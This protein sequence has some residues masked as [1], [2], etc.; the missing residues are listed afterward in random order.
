MTGA[1]V[2]RSMAEGLPWRDGVAQ[3]CVTSPPYWGLRRYGDHPDELGTE[4][5]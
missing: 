1:G 4:D 2:V 3:V 5:L